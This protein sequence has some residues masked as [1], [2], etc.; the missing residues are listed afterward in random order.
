MYIVT[1]ICTHLR[2]VE[3][4]EQHNAL[5]LQIEKFPGTEFPFLLSSAVEMISFLA[6][7]VKQRNAL[8]AY[9]AS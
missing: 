2:A 3:H 5:Q 8:P 6:V 4:L 9:I 7:L 1:W